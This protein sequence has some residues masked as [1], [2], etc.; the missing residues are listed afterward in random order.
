MSLIL[1]KC[2]HLSAKINVFDPHPLPPPSLG[3][4]P[5]TEAS[6]KPACQRSQTVQ[7]ASQPA[8]RSQTG[9]TGPGAQSGQSDK[10]KWPDFV[11][12]LTG[13]IL[14]EFG[15]TPDA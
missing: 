10:R 4:Q 6:L 1:V 8:K 12:F 3:S 9:P 2:Q 5:A 13:D 14:G 7:V 11:A 15:G